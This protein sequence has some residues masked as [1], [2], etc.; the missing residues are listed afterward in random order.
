[1]EG[2]GQVVVSLLISV[3][4]LGHK[5]GTVNGIVNSVNRRKEIDEVLGQL[6]GSQ[7]QSQLPPGLVKQARRLTHRD[8]DGDIVQVLTVSVGLVCGRAVGVRR[9]MHSEPGDA[10]MCLRHSFFD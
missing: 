6:E 2:L 5:V 10:C 1:M 8:G 7:S 9:C 3:L 4:M